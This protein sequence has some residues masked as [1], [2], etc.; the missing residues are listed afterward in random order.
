MIRYLSENDV[1]QLLT[2]QD[3]IVQ[4]ERAFRAR[5]VGKAFDIPRVRT[6]QPGGHLHILQA[7]APDLNYIGY[8]A[9]YIQPDKSRT[10]L[11]H[12]INMSQGNLEAMIQAD[13][14]GQIRTGAASAV[15]VQTLARKSSK[16]LGLF[17]S[18]RHAR[19]QL[20]AVSA[21]CELDEVRVFG[22]DAQRVLTFCEQMSTKVGVT[23]RP[24][25]SREE[26]V[27]GADIVLTITRSNEP[28]FDGKWIEPGQTIIAVGSNAMD[29]REI[30]LQT[31]S[32]ADLIVA[33]S[34]QVAQN[35]SGDLLSAYEKGLI[36]WENIP[37]LG[38]ILVKQR[39][40]RVNDEQIILFESQGMAL[41]DIYTGAH[42]LEL[43]H[44]RGL[45][46]NFPID[47]Q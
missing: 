30:D 6:R 2:M 47:A 36:Y 41:Q 28:L 26:T 46:Q 9:Y 23:V 1:R 34:V 4:V 43:A 12:L 7:A 19:T 22:R 14:L 39:D 16:I 21:V 5:A 33:D 11:L 10:S 13:W 35:E 38:Q 17:G 37:D 32:K 3:A 18:G 31:V 20:E 44:R 42:L 29:R 27:K 8:K 24:A 15:A 45:G 40:G 25:M